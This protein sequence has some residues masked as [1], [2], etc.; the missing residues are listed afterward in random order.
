[1]Q[2]ERR[3]SGH[4]SRAA[5]ADLWAPSAWWCS[6]AQSGRS[7]W[8]TCTGGRVGPAAASIRRMLRGCCREETAARRQRVDAFQTLRMHLTYCS[9]RCSLPNLPL[10]ASSCPTYPPR[11]APQPAA[12]WRP[13]RPPHRGGSRTLE[14]AA[15]RRPP[16]EA[17]PGGQT[18]VRQGSRGVPGAA[19]LAYRQRSRLQHTPPR[20]A[21]AGQ[22][23]PVLELWS[24]R[25]QPV[26]KAAP[27][28]QALQCTGTCAA[29]QVAGSLR[30]PPG[31]LPA[32]RGSHSTAACA[33][34]PTWL[35]S[36]AA[37]LRTERPG[38]A[39]C[40][41]HR[42]ARCWRWARR[43]AR[44]PL[45]PARRCPAP[46][47]AAA[48]CPASVAPASHPP[49]AAAREA[50]GEATGSDRCAGRHSVAA[51]QA[52]KRGAGPQP[53]PARWPGTLARYARSNP[54]WQ[55][56]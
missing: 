7:H 43:R 52:A 16:R 11:P 12:Q 13:Y 55:R 27:S 23:P 30:L 54:H 32:S 10:S 36:L 15:S 42:W 3:E 47:V 28:Q 50:G 29:S 17:A 35:A 21:R 39:H 5:S 53:W 1:M 34:C 18:S 24:R 45:P 25:Q 40:A 20:R 6:Q 2:L 31:H 33:S 38:R 26:L 8:V 9:P 56:A 22:R 49:Q 41:Q 4:G 44:P 51:Q 14:S 37:T 46:A 19:C 48:V